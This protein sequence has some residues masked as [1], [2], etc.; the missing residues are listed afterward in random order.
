MIGYMAVEAETTKIIANIGRKL[1]LNGSVEIDVVD[2]ARS[3]R[4]RA[5]IG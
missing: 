1:M 3:P 4:Q 5:P 2:G